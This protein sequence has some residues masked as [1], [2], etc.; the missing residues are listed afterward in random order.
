MIYYLSVALAEQAIIDAGYKRDP[1]RAMWVNAAGKTAKVMR[2]ASGKFY[3]Q[4][5]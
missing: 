3:V 1:Q 2:E 4:W 5:S